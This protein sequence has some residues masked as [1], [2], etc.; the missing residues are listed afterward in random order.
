MKKKVSSDH[1]VKRRLAEL[2]ELSRLCRGDIVKMTTI[3]GS[4]HPAG[5]MSSIDL[6]LAL[7]TFARISPSNHDD[8]RR[9]RIIVSHG[10]TSPALYACLARLGFVDLESVLLGFRKLTSPFESAKL[11]LIA[12]TTSPSPIKNSDRVNS[13]GIVILN[14]FLLKL[15]Y[16]IAIKGPPIIIIIVV[17][18]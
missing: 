11:I 4:G 15:L 12:R 5:S 2:F 18:F 9:D 10:H 1:R 14:P 13:T 8:P 3:A 16:K 7:F 6:Y 17:M